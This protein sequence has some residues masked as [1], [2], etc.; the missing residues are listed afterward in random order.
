MGFDV[1][2]IAQVARHGNKQHGGVAHTAGQVDVIRI[3]R[4]VLSVLIAAAYSCS[5]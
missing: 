5:A 3:F 4:L 1:A 2:D